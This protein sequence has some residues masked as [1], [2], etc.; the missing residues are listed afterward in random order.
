MVNYSK[1]GEKIEERGKEWKTKKGLDE[2]KIEK[3]Q[4]H[5]VI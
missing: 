2:R 3:K 4:A 5:T 1:S